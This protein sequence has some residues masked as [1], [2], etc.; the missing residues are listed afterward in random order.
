MG[1]CPWNN[2]E[3]S[4]AVATIPANAT[5]GRTSPLR[6]MKHFRARERGPQNASDDLRR[7]AKRACAH[8]PR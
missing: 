3:R 5:R 2:C 7:T 4:F 1:C 6:Q 8:Q